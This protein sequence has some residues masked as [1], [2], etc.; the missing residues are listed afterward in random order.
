MV[1]IADVKN[2]QTSWNSIKDKWETDH[3]LN[4]YTT[5]FDDVPE[6]KSAFVKAGNKT[7]YQ[8]KGQA[9]RF[10]R[11]VTEWIDN[12]DN[13]EALVAKINGMCATHRTRGITNV[14]LF[15]VA[16]GELVKYIAGK[17]SF[18]KAQRES[19][20]VV[21]GCIIQTMRNYF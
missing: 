13:E 12:L 18:T 8:V 11:M 7:D 16:L 14:D 6:I 21:N 20:A 10:G 2:V 5:L 3:G 17:T 19:W 4:F 15:E 9:V 1:T